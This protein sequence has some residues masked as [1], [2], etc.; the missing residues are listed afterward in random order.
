MMAHTIVGSIPT[1][2]VKG[3]PC[4]MYRIEV[5]I[6]THKKGFLGE[7]KRFVKIASGMM[8]GL[9]YVLMDV[10]IMWQISPMMIILAIIGKGE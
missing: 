7:G 8:R 9:L 10:H 4:S 3:S 2:D 1:T 6:R 5:M